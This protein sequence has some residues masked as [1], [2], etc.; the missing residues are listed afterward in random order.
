MG[1]AGLKQF[2][3]AGVDFHVLLCMGEIAETCPASNGY[4]REIIELGTATNFVADELLKL[5][6]GENVVA[7]MSAILPVMPDTSCDTLVLKLFEACGVS[8]VKTPGFG[9]LRSLRNTL[10]SLVRRTKFKDKVFQYHQLMK[11]LLNR[12]VPSSPT[13]TLEVYDSIPSEETA[14]QIILSLSK[15]IREDSKTVIAYYGLKG[16]AWII[17]YARHVLGV[18]VCVLKSA[19]DPVPINGDYKD[20]RVLLYIFAGENRCEVL[21]QGQVEDFFEI[22]S[23]ISERLSEGTIDT[24]KTNVLDSYL[25]DS[26]SLRKGASDIVRSLVYSYTEV[27]ARGLYFENRDQT[28]EKHG[29]IK[30]SVYCLPAI[31]QRAWRILEL[32][33]FGSSEEG[34]DESKGWRQ[35]ISMRRSRPTEVEVQSGQKQGS[36][37]CAAALAPGPA[38]IR[39]DIGHI[40]TYGGSHENPDPSGPHGTHEAFEFDENG[41]QHIT[42]LLRIAEATSWLAFTNWDQN[43]RI[44]STAFLEE[45]RSWKK[46]LFFEVPLIDILDS[47]RGDHNTGDIYRL[48]N[49]DSREKMVRTHKGIT[50]SEIFNITFQISTSGRQGWG[51]D[52]SDGS[53]VAYHHRGI[54]LAQNAIIHQRLDLEACYVYFLPGVIIANGERREAVNSYSQRTKGH[55]FSQQDQHDQETSYKPMDMFPRLEFSPRAE[56]TGDA[57]ILRHGVLINDQILPTAFPIYTSAALAWL[58]VTNGCDHD[59]YAEYQF[60]PP[61]TSTS[62]S[63]R[64]EKLKQGLYLSGDRSNDSL[65]IDTLTCYLQAVDRNPCGQWIAYQNP[66]LSMQPYTILQR[67]TCIEC[68]CQMIEKVCESTIG[69]RK[70]CVIAGRLEGEAID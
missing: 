36:N 18:L 59:Y 6:A 39:S 57:I 5:R 40:N 58:F 15:L 52:F 37:R 35:Y 7:L 20:A 26:N 1:A 21:T 60:T 16:A 9:Q 49:M 42:F 66:A 44:V 50:V 11:N 67:K 54:I 65:E 17:A 28:L 46:C 32:F 2:A 61:N 13:S 38:W 69:F 10:A 48:E 63:P 19:S 64:I 41:M 4:R 51:P 14:V 47:E 30:Y 27:L 3:E 29:L 33:G 55:F 23:L 45:R 25:P 62:Q 34:I 43:L 70:V 22:R 53:L 8:L 12:D 68:T 56:V 24:D 31:R